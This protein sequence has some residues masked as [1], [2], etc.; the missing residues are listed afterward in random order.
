MTTRIFLTDEFFSGFSVNS[1]SNRHKHN[2]RPFCS[3]LK[4]HWGICY[5]SFNV[6][7]AYI[8][9]TIIGANRET[10]RRSPENEKKEGGGFEGKQRGGE[11]LFDKSKEKGSKEDEGVGLWGIV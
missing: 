1:Y 3:V 10:G 4:L 9:F 11:G 7:L 8:S 5:P 6:D 2:Y